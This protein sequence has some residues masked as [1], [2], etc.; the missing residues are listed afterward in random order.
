MFFVILLKHYLSLFPLSNGAAD[1]AI[2]SNRSPE[3]PQD[4]L[5]ILKIVPTTLPAKR[6]V[7]QSSRAAYPR[8]ATVESSSAPL[9]SFINHSSLIIWPINQSSITNDFA[10]SYKN[11][12]L[13]LTIIFHSFPTLIRLL[14]TRLPLLRGSFLT[15]CCH[16]LSSYP[17]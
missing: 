14:L 2:G 9:H 17:E 12:S 8:S 5:T 15:V 4:H 16:N 10:A 3:V 13:L 7:Y 6:V 11:R 1:F